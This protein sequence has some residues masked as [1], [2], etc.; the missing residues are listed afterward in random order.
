MYCRKCGAEIP[1]DS[2]FCP[3]CGTAIET[4]VSPE[5]V[6]TDTSEQ[7]DRTQDKPMRCGTCFKPLTARMEKCPNCD[8]PNPFF[9]GVRTDDSCLSDI[10]ELNKR[11]K[12][13][14]VGQ[15]Q[16]KHRRIV[17]VII[18]VTSV[19]AVMAAAL[20]FLL[21]QAGI[22][23]E[24]E[25]VQDYYKITQYTGNSQNVTIPDTIWFKPVAAIA[26]NAFSMRNDKANAVNVKLGKNI[27]QIHENA[28]K[29]YSSLKELDCSAVQIKSGCIFL[30]KANAFENCTNLEKITF[31][32]ACI[33]IESSAFKKCSSLEEIYTFDQH[34]LY[35]SENQN[36][37]A[38][39]GMFE[40]N[41]NPFE[42]NSIIG[43]QA[44]EG[45]TSLKNLSLINTR[46]EYNSFEN[47]TG[48]TE[49]IMTG[50]NLGDIIDENL[51]LR[52]KCLKRPGGGA[53][54]G[55]TDL[56]T[57]ELNFL[58][59]NPIPNSTFYGCTTLT[60]VSEANISAIG[61]NA[62]GECTS[63][64][65]V[66]FDPYPTDVAYNAFKGCN[67]FQSKNSSEKSKLAQGSLLLGLS[68]TY[69]D[70]ATEFGMPDE[71]EEGKVIYNIGNMKYCIWYDFDGHPTFDPDCADTIRCVEV[72]G[73]KNINFY[74]DMHLGEDLSYYQNWAKRVDLNSYQTEL[75]PWTDEQGNKF[76]YYT[77]NNMDDLFL[78]LYFDYNQKIA[79]S[80]L[81][82][83]LS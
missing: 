25:R 30:V 73:D 40:D 66:E 19:L 46:L 60:N 57:V 80:A 12:S 21:P 56:K 76:Y 33:N 1:D 36:F 64:S 41:G 17:P 5:E 82:Y 49:I 81:G 69:K 22:G 43:S 71:Y 35:T 27:S 24:Y 14:E 61:D 38:T 52:E 9:E 83:T 44:F 75:S 42:K 58:E 7:N 31:P 79:Y 23:F 2:V 10:R 18:T 70:F 45:C 51:S 67:S 3:K 16:R 8:T 48:V 62:F 55:C 63:L 6:L 28:F 53:F 39:I 74:G 78:E 77:M 15:E 20:I 50:G 34:I 65:L 4:E 29:D 72:N 13:G 26:S 59:K 37:K 47:C 68:T 32:H 54:K 11:I